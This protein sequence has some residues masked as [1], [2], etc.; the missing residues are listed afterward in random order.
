ML[1]NATLIGSSSFNEDNAAT[2]VNGADVYWA[3]KLVVPSLSYNSGIRQNA[4]VDVKFTALDGTTNVTNIPLRAYPAGTYYFLAG[5]QVANSPTTLPFVYNANEAEWG[6]YY[7]WPVSAF[8]SFSSNNIAETPV[9]ATN[10]LDTATAKVEAKVYSDRPLSTTY[11]TVGSYDI[12]IDTTDAVIFRKANSN[13]GTGEL[14]AVFMRDGDDKVTDVYASVSSAANTPYAGQNWTTDS[15]ALI[16]LYEWLNEGSATTF[17][18]ALDNDEVYMTNA[19][20]RAAFGFS[21][22][23]SDS[24]T[25]N[26]NSTPIILD[27]T[28]SIPKT[29]DNASVIGFAMIMVAVVAAAVAVRKVNA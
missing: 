21:Y 7:F 17:Q 4:Q 1:S 8:G 16:K 15:S 26:A 29:G 23:Q 5:G 24:V 14:V 10:C 19:N 22:S 28:V 27:P 25:W 9:Y 2:A 11:F 13:I 6:T 18:T 20:L 3:I 12:C